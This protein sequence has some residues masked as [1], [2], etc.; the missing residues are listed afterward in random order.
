MPTYC[1]YITYQFYAKLW[2]K[3]CAHLSRCLLCVLY[4]H[5]KHHS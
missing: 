1:N 2:L 3:F 4:K 5:K